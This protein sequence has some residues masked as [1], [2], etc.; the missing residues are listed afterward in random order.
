MVN[1]PIEQAWSED[2]LVVRSLISRSMSGPCPISTWI[3]RN[4]S[5][6]SISQTIGRNELFDVE[7][8]V[9][10]GKRLLDFDFFKTVW[11]R[12]LIMKHWLPVV[13]YTQ[14]RLWDTSFLSVSTALESET[15]MQM[16]LFK[17]D[18]VGSRFQTEICMVDEI[19]CKSFNFL[20]QA[21]FLAACIQLFHSK[22]IKL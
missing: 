12:F 7:L 21:L 19:Y 4:L 6:A 13:D 1:W 9:Y 2:P 11:F 14:I 16:E 20:R 22:G 5:L 8:S 18:W 15:H 17:L 3:G 10:Q